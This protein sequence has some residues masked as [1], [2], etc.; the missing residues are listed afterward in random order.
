MKSTKFAGLF[1]IIPVLTLVLVGCAK[2][3][4]AEKE[5]AKAAMDAAISAGADKYVSAD[6]EAAKKVW[7]TAESQMK[8]KK[9]KEAKQSYIDAKAAFEKAA[10]GV[11]AGKK[12]ITDQANTALSS[13]EES[14][15]NVEA[16]AKKLGKKLKDREAWASDSKAISKGLAKTKELVA[17]DPSEAK[18]KLDELKNMVDK[19]ENKF[20]EMGSRPTGSGQE[21]AK[22]EGLPKEAKGFTINRMLVGTG[23]EN[24]EPV[25][26]AETFPSITEKVYCY[27]E[28]TDIVK[29]TEVSFV[30]FHG[31]NEI[32]RINLPL[33][34]GPK[35]RT[36]AF[37]NLRGTKGEWKVELK[38]VDGSLL[39]DIKFKVE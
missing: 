18:S 25:G 11:E 15:K 27:L 14:W 13:I 19:W 36:W 7:E 2:P 30:W 8:D 5:A 10:A 4:E 22:Q 16:T 6:M 35:W 37:K 1:F 17:T 9:Y 29:D 34:M 23:V 24:G 31:G 39:K 21:K 33:K 38:D 26:V 32:T 12:A 20:K 3:P 28:A